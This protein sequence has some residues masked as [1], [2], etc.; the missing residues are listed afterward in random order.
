MFIAGRFSIMLTSEEVLY[1]ITKWAYYIIRVEWAN[2]ISLCI[3]FKLINILQLWKLRIGTVTA[4]F[5][6]SSFLI[7]G[8][9][10]EHNSNSI[11]RCYVI[12]HV[13][14]IGKFLKITYQYG[15]IYL[16]IYNNNK[17]KMFT[18]C[19]WFSNAML[20]NQIPCCYHV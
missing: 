12:T 8:T 15:Y 1:I 5:R 20:K 19:Y 14:L 2:T 9:L 18:E 7:D 6:K 13:V 16:H 11:A 3:K 4:V 17:L 10:F